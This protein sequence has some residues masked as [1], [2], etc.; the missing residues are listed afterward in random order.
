MRNTGDGYTYNLGQDTV[1]LSNSAQ[2]SRFFF[3]SFYFIFIS[4][5]IGA[6]QP[7]HISKGCFSVPDRASKVALARMVKSFACF[8]ESS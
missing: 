1:R 2:G 5:G 3:I 8:Q 6:S 7:I 4:V